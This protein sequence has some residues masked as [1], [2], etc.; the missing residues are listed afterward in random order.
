[1]SLLGSVDA[2]SNRRETVLKKWTEFKQLA[3]ERRGM[4]I[5]A[6]RLQQFDR[7][8]NELEGWMQGKLKITSDDSHLDSSN[9]EA[10]FGPRIKASSLT[11]V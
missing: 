5:D 10:S 6:K 9:L 11:F 7:N 2:I 3:A 8:A 1:M 4:L